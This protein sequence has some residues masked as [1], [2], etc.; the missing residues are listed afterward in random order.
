VSAGAAAL[1]ALV[2]LASW[3]GTAGMR[4]YAQALGVLDVPN[5]RSSHR[6]PTPRGGG[7]AIAAAVL[8]GISAA[9]LAGWLSPRFAAAA[10]GGGAAVAWSGWRDDRR[11][12]SPWF[13]LAVQAAAALW[14]IAWIG[15]PTA[16]AFGR[17]ALAVG[18]LGAVLAL[19]W[20]VWLT[21]L[22]NFMDGIDGIASAE[23]VV[24]GGIGGALLVSGGRPDLATAA[25][26]VGAGAL[27]FLYWNWAP[28]S[29]FMGDVGSGFLG[30]LF[31]ILAVQSE[32]AGAV[33]LWAW[34]LL[35]GAFIFDATLTLV[36]RAIAGEV[37]YAAHRSH[38][39]QR[40]VASGRSHRA[41]SWA[42][43]ALTSGLGLLAAMGVRARSPARSLAAGLIGL[44]VVYLIVERWKPMRTPS[45]ERAS[46]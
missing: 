39:Y 37:W 17:S 42:L 15:A 7:L 2:A 27:G 38:A 29:I 24:A 43:V 18:P 36:R 4:R 20:I 16:L 26:V 3:W 6:V 33:P 35:L 1:V 23:A 45:G 32:Q 40:A 13:R 44:T 5:E 22:F 28:A 19:L 34:S 12:S 9:A 8:G 11:S 10:I 41:V 25:L 31:G 30:F 14:A 21:N 46:T